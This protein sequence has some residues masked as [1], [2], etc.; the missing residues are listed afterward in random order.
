M[1]T[2]TTEPRA[3]R[4]PFDSA[5]GSR[6]CVGPSVLLESVL[7][8]RPPALYPAVNASCNATADEPP[9]SSKS[10]TTSAPGEGGGVV[11]RTC[12]IHGAWAQQRT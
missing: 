8:H 2:P 10:P 7:V 11:K 12:T 4:S 3:S 1:P 5:G 9:P 6:A